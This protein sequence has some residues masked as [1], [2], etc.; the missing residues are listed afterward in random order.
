VVALTHLRRLELK[1]G[2]AGIQRTADD[3]MDDIRHLHSVLTMT[4]LARKPRR[5]LEKPTSTQAEILSAFG[6]S[7]DKNGVLQG[8][9]L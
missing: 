4:A 9:S 5:R 7:I 6:C 8:E 2:N 1:L 3:V